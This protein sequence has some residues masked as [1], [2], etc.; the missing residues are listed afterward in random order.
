MVGF[1]QP[2]C[3]FAN[4]KA[5]SLDLS[6]LLSQIFFLILK[7]KVSTHQNLKDPN[8]FVNIKPYLRRIVN[9]RK[10]TIYSN[11]RLAFKGG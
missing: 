10:L 4:F 6:L 3:I 8:S 1:S 5:L 2:G 9:F 11:L 7:I